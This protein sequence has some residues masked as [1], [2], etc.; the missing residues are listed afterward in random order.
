[1]ARITSFHESGERYTSL[2]IIGALFTL[3]G[4]VLLA[5]GTLLL[6]FGLYS[7]LAGTTGGP[8]P[9][10][11]PFA[12]RPVGVVSLGAGLGGLLSLLWSFGFLL[13]GLQLV[14]LG[15]LFR[16]LI[17]LEENTRTSAQSLDKIRMRLESRGEGV[18]PLFRS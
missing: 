7:L 5:I 8:P 11:G 6:V 13:S 16:L 17:H 3:I 18:E 9:G 2:R 10:A 12:A 1:M 15:A 4:A 14:A